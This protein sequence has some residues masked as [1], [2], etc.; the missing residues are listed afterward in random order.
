M[1]SS[2]STGSV[3][4]LGASANRPREPVD[5]LE[6]GRRSRELADDRRRKRVALHGVLAVAL[7][8]ARGRVALELENLL[9]QAGVCRRLEEVAKLDDAVLV[10]PP[11]QVA[12]GAVAST[13]DT[14]TVAAQRGR[15][16]AGWVKAESLRRLRADRPDV[17]LVTTTNAAGNE[18]I[19]ALNR[20]LGFERVAVATT[21]SVSLEG[22][23]VQ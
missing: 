2:G 15:G 19:L 7:V 22:A 3:A 5:E 1:I 20:R 21:A 23:S 11:A 6:D 12:Q 14:A 18:P 10:E 17:R 16:L 8:E 13:E 9:A 4:W